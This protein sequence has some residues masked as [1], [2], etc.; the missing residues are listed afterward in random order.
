M[1]LESYRTDLEKLLAEVRQELTTD[2]P[3]DLMKSIHLGHAFRKESMIL[4]EIRE[5]ETM[6][7]AYDLTRRFAELLKSLGAVGA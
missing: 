4:S 7:L 2:G 5:I 6:T 3:V 1:T